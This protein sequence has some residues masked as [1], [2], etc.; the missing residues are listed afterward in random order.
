MKYFN[1]G[2][3]SWMFEII[4]KPE[5]LMALFKLKNFNSGPKLSKETV[6]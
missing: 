2:N 4:F 6:R 1:F 3:V 5:P